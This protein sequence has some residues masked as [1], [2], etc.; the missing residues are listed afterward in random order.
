MEEE[1]TKIMVT[2]M[3][4]MEDRGEEEVLP[5]QVTCL[6]QTEV[7]KAA[8]DEKCAEKRFAHRAE[9]YTDNKDWASGEC[10]HHILKK[11][12]L[13]YLHLTPELTEENLKL[14][15]KYFEDEDESTEMVV[16]CNGRVV[17]SCGTSNLKRNV[18]IGRFLS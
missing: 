6:A 17:V 4:W 1:L 8:D 10:R 11:D 5:V 2:V 12:D 7:A 16:G 18:K 14:V 15:V 3:V 13:P 9:K